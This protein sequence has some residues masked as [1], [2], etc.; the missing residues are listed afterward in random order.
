[1]KEWQCLPHIEVEVKSRISELIINAF[2]IAPFRKSSHM[3]P[4]GFSTFQPNNHFS[5]SL[6]GIMRYL[7]MKIHHSIGNMF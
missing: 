6:V 4:T 3:E 7:Y 5:R 1:M 2:I